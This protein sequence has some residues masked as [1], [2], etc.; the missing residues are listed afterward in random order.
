M[1]FPPGKGSLQ[2]VAI[3]V[4]MEVAKWLK[5]SGVEG[6]LGRLGERAGRNVIER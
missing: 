4:V 1:R 6:R 5:H 2:P 3:G